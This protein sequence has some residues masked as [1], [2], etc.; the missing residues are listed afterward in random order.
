M[1]T[2][3]CYTC[4]DASTRLC[5]GF[6]KDPLT[7]CWYCN[8]AVGGHFFP[9]HWDQEKGEQERKGEKRNQKEK[10]IERKKKKKRRRVKQCQATMRCTTNYC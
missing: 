6:V 4:I 10:E 7:T 1:M 9:C 5:L 3:P 8:V 2:V